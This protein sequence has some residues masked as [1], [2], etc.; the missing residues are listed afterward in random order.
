MNQ[1]R[2]GGLSP[3][4]LRYF[5]VG[6]LNT[7]LNALLFN[8]FIWISGVARGPLI[9]VFSL[10]SF[11]IT[12]IHSYLWNRFWVFRQHTFGDT[13]HLQLFS[14]FGIVAVVVGVVGSSLLYIITTVIGAP[15]GIAPQLWANIA[16]VI[17][18]PVAFASN[19]LGNRFLVFR[20]E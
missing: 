5:F 19:Y 18:A 4:V 13:T 3:Y 8:L 1:T 10:V 14:K 11:S 17:T 15:A 9:V 2:F 6:C 20:Q 7:L 12:L 16:L